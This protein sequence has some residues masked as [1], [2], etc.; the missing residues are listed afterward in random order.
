MDHH[1]GPSSTLVVVNG[2]SPGS[3]RDVQIFRPEPVTGEVRGAVFQ[4]IVCQ[5]E[6]L[7][8]SVEVR[9]A[10]P[11]LSETAKSSVILN[12]TVVIV[13]LNIHSLLPGAQSSCIC[14]RAQICS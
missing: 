2:V 6:F 5:P 3:I 11:C 12:W 10:T 13:P 1:G 9:V 7:A 8:W 4:C 14:E